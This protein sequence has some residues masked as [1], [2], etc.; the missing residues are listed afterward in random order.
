MTEHRDEL[1]VPPVTLFTAVACVDNRQARTRENGEIRQQPD[2]FEVESA[3]LRMRH[4]PDGAQRSVI[5]RNRNDNTFRHFHAGKPKTRKPGLRIDEKLRGACLQ[6][7]A[8]RALIPRGGFA[9]Q[10]GAK[11]GN[12]EPA[13]DPTIVRSFDQTNPRAISMTKGQSRIR[14]SL[15]EFGTRAGLNAGECHQRPVFG[16][17][18]CGASR[19]AGEL[20]RLTGRAIAFHG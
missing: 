4:D 1:V 20:I 8:A 13:K 2:V 3:I 5:R 16:R 11:S 19:P 14:D 9:A 12:R 10:V 15:K 17:V 6:C 7:D 18:I